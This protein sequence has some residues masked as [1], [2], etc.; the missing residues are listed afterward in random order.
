M[1]IAILY[2]ALIICLISSFVELKSIIKPN[3]NII[4]GVTLPYEYLNNE[5]VLYIVNNYKK[6]AFKF[7]ALYLFSTLP[8]FILQDYASLVIIFFFIWIGIFL[9]ANDRLYLKYFRTLLKL[10]KDRSWF[11]GGKHALSIDTEVCRIK[12]KLSFSKLW[13]I[14]SIVI[15]IIP[16]I[17]FIVKINIFINMPFLVSLIPIA[18][19]LAFIYLYNCFTK[20]RAESPS[21]NSEINLAYTMIYQKSWSLLW[22]LS[23]FVTSISTLVLYYN[24]FSNN[25][26]MFLIIVPITASV[27]I[28]AAILFTYTKVRSEQSSLLA[29]TKDLIYTDNDEFWEKG[30]YSN[31]YDPRLMVENRVGYGL[32]YNLATT[33][34]KIINYSFYVILFVVFIGFSIFFLRLDFT[35]FYLSIDG[36]HASVEAPMYDYSFDINEIEDIKLL[37]ELPPKGIKTNGVGTNLYSLGNYKLDGY[38]NCKVFIYRKSPP[39]ICIKLKDTYVFLN[40]FTPEETNNYY[41]TLLK[42]TK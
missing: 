40:G 36:T 8:I 35:K 17:T 20:Q 5:E 11:V 30:Y 41:E 21:E 24:I 31:P 28:S 26:N 3:K 19:T 15:S 6:A 22:I 23:A 37:N 2:L 42:L 39:F 29:T 18:S 33:K 38:G 34:G 32:C 4:L 13:F 27:T 7:Y 10:K 16:I 9:Y 25:P 12:N 14:P 1:F